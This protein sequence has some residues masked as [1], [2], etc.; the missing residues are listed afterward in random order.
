[1]KG[2]QLILVIILLLGASLIVF[3]SSPVGS[4]PGP[5]GMNSRHWSWGS[6]GKGNTGWLIPADTLISTSYSMNQSVSSFIEGQIIAFT[7]QIQPGTVLYL[8]LY[9]NGQLAASQNY[10]LKTSYDNPA[11][12]VG[13]MESGIANFSNSRLVFTVSELNLKT[14]IPAGTMLTVTAWASNP[15][16][17]QVDNPPLTNSYETL[18]S[19][20]STPPSAIVPD[21]GVIAQHTISVSGGGI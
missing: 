8:G 17:V 16:W 4:L 1:M 13:N 5:L 14:T 10:T 18:A 9:L 6:P 7:Y 2:S 11:F 12:V 20:T 19:T 3:A 21:S 15:V